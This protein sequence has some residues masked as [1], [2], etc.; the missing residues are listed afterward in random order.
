ML[1]NI[2]FTSILSKVLR[3]VATPAEN[4][5]LAVL[6][7]FY[8]RLFSYTAS[9]ID[10]ITA[11]P[12]LT[13]TECGKAGLYQVKEGQNTYTTATDGYCSCYKPNC[14]HQQLI[15]TLSGSLSGSL[16][17]Q[18]GKVKIKS[19]ALR[20]LATENTRAWEVVEF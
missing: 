17:S 1:L 10:A 4:K 3:P 8:S 9:L 14:N 15:R 19:P 2:N 18:L 20:K 5:P 13:A 6:G 16:V 11:E 7:K 12:E